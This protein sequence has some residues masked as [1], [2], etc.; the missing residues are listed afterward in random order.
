MMPQLKKLD[1]N[2]LNKLQSLEQTS[3]HCIVAWEPEPEAPKFADI[4]QKEVEELQSLEKD[5]NSVL[6]VYK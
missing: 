1:G 6:L 2:S 4:S 5:L 3:G